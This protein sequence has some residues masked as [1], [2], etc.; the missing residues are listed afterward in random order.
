MTN[1]CWTWSTGSGSNT[2][3]ATTVYT[4]LSAKRVHK[5][6]QQTTEVAWF[7]ASA[8]KQMRY[9]LFCDYTQRR[10]V[11][12]CRRFGKTYPS[13]GVGR[14]LL[15][16]AA[17]N[18]K[19]AQI[20]DHRTSQSETPVTLQLNYVTAARNINTVELGYDVMKETE[21]FFVINECCYNRGEK[22]YA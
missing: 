7:Q 22:C 20:S 16:Y 18:P 12:P 10:I 2:K 6:S 17:Y 8:A 4:V 14:E 11:A 19:R 5:T 1:C 21:C 15:F 13:Q 3:T 9:A